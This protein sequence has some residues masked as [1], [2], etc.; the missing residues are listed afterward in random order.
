MNALRKNLVS[1]MMVFVV[2]ALLGISA[3]CTFHAAAE[4]TMGAGRSGNQAAANIKSG[5]PHGTYGIFPPQ[6]SDHKPVKKSAEGSSR[7]ARDDN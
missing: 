1:L 2:L 4:T 6:S 5:K 3:G 7:P